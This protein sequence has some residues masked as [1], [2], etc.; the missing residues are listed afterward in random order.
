MRI[1]IRRQLVRCWGDTGS[2]CSICAT[3]CGQGCG[4]G[5][6]DTLEMGLQ[7]SWDLLQRHHLALV[8][9]GA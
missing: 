8:T 6:G 7:S 4:L 2:W 9:G 5:A 3:L 1:L